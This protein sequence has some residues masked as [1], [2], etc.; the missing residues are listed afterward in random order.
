M[1]HIEEKIARLAE[2]DCQ[3]EKIQN[4]IA[5]YAAKYTEKLAELNAARNAIEAEI[6]PKIN[7]D[8]FP[9]KAKSAKFG[10]YRY[11][12]RLGND[13][14]QVADTETAI[15]ILRE[16]NCEAYIRVTESVNKKQISE[17]PLPPEL[18]AKAGITLEVGKDQPF[19]KKV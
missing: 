3:I 13:I 8:M 15:A 18:A 5:N 6:L 16:N 9:G 17:A 1:Q 19:I 12:V 4:Q 14:W 7:K 2:V 11:G 10:G